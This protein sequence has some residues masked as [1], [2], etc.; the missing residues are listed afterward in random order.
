MTD[1][2]WQM[3]GRWMDW[4]LMTRLDRCS[5][6]DRANLEEEKKEVERDYIWESPAGKG[7]NKQM[8]GYMYVLLCCVMHVRMDVCLCLSRFAA[9]VAGSEGVNCDCSTHQI[10][11]QPP[12]PMQF[13]LECLECLECPTYFLLVE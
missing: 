7:A 6:L 8:D 1:D 10:S 4:Y 3:D 9:A 12:R 5:H 13:S 2:R 11:G